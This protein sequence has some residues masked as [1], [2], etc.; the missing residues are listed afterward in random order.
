M[1]TKDMPL[2]GGIAEKNSVQA[3]RP[4]A[5]APIPTTGKGNRGGFSSPAA[6][7]ETE[8]ESSG[9]SGT[10]FIY[11]SKPTIFKVQR[12]LEKGTISEE[13]EEEGC[14]YGGN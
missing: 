2:S 14:R 9:N 7:L 12:S 10:S 5:E 6:S 11:R 13:F 4:P 8:F 1:S 3:S